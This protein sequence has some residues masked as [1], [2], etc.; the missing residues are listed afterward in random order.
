MPVPHGAQ[1]SSPFNNAP[2][3]LRASMPPMRPFV[4]SAS[5][6]RLPQA[7][8]NQGVVFPLIEGALVPVWLS[9]SR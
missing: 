4:R 6:T 2:Y 1:Q 9:G 8:V 5:W 7:G 3:R